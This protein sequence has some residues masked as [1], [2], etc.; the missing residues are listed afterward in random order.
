MTAIKETSGG[1]AWKT[2]NGTI[3]IRV[4]S[5]R[6]NVFLITNGMQH[7]LVDTSISLVWRRL[8]RNLERMNI[9]HI[10]YLVLTHSHFDHAANAGKV[11][12]KFGAKVVIHEAEADPLAN[13]TF[14]IPD[15]TIPITRLMTGA[16]RKN[17][18][19]SFRTTP[20]R[21]DLRAG[22]GFDLKDSGYNVSLLHTPGHSPG[23]MSV[24]VDDEIALVGDAMVGTFRWTVFPPFA[25][26]VPQLIE[27]WGKLLETRCTLFLPSHGS[28][29]S[30]TLVETDYLKRKQ[31]L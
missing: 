28:A 20:C 16:L 22:A 3:I 26:D 24:I 11:R 2:K 4:M 15:G 8:A 7:I 19:L 27:S 13:G 21:S 14:L 30:R 9:R 17:N 12:E 18:R 6:S 31:S 1:K 25:V 23:S 5:G 29:R 10:D